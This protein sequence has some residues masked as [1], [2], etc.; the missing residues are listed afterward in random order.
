MEP[1]GLT[2]SVQNTGLSDSSDSSDDELTATMKSYSL[3]PTMTTF[4]ANSMTTYN[5]ADK[6]P[7]LKREYAEI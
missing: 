3:N 2:I 6:Y 1:T 7:K 4:D 5:T